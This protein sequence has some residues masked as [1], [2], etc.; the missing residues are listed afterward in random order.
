[1]RLD[2]YQTVTVLDGFNITQPANGQLLARI[3]TDVFSSIQV[4]PAREPAEFGKGSGGLLL[5]NT[6]MG[7]DHFRFFA[8]DFVPSYQNKCKNM[9]LLS[10]VNS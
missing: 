4:K 10:N 8:T 6:G 5:L 1:M 7:N 2:T 9:M 3:S